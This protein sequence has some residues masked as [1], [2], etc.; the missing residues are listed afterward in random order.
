MWGLGGWVWLYEMGEGYLKV[1]LCF[2]FVY[3][4][5]LATLVRW[6]ILSPAGLGNSMFMTI[7]IGGYLGYSH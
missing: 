6:M 3:L 5:S 2:C 4:A 1:L 7:D